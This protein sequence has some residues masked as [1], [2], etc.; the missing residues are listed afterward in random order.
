MA[1]WYSGIASLDFPVCTSAR[2]RLVSAGALSRIC[3]DNVLKQWYCLLLLSAGLQ[4]ESQ[5]ILC[6]E[7]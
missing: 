6:V 5:L 7:R 2:P 3:S 1:R 4:G